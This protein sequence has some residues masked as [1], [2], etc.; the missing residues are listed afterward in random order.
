MFLRIEKQA[1]GRRADVIT[2]DMAMKWPGAQ[3]LAVP[4]PVP[5][6]DHDI[7]LQRV[8]GYND[9]PANSCAS[10]TGTKHIR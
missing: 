10:T 2:F 1:R 3:A 5:A 9:S 4:V 7:A 8:Y 6:C